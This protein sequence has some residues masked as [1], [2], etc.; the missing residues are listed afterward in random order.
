MIDQQVDFWF[1]K[2]V[3]HWSIKRLVDLNIRLET[4]SGRIS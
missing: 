3:I 1:E 2:F 4:K